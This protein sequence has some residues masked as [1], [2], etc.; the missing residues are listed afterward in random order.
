MTCE[1]SDAT[2]ACRHCPGCTRPADHRL[3]AAA[4]T[5]QAEQWYCSPCLVALVDWLECEAP[6]TTPLAKQARQLRDSLHRRDE[7]HSGGYAALG[8]EGFRAM[9]IF[10]WE[11][12]PADPAPWPGPLPP[13]PGWP[14]LGSFYAARG[15]ARS[16]EADYGVWH[17]AEGI[18]GAE[19]CRWRVSVVASTGDCYAN[20][21]CS[22][23]HHPHVLLLGAVQPDPDFGDAD[24][25]F[26]GWERTRGRDLRWFRERSSAPQPVHSPP[27]PLPEVL[28]ARR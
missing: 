6:L 25:R 22:C 15:G 27:S 18:A 5:T 2:R 10:G 11:D 26:R 8:V 23:T 1:G 16:P 12:A 13:A 24:R 14:S 7:K 3:G 28:P 20:A 17:R 21:V 4:T 19:S 9:H